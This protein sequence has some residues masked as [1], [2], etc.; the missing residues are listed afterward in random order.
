VLEQVANWLEAYAEALDLN[1]WLSSKVTH[2]VYVPESKHWK[3][4]VSTQPEREKSAMERVF[5]VNHVIFA[6]GFRGGEENMPSYPGMDKF[7]GPIL[8]SMQHRRALDYQGKKVVV[9]GSCT[10]GWWCSC[11]VAF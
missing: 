2:A 7:K 11:Q 9:I 4:T 10:S 6:T 5:T 3:V 8:H 1:V